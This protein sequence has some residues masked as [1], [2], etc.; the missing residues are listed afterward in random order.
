LTAALRVLIKVMLQ[1][2]N[3]GGKQRLL[4]A[5]YSLG[6]RPGQRG[7]NTNEDR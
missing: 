3:P 2:S 4:R 5:V 1:R 6:L 7:N